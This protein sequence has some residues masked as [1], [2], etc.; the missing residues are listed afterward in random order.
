MNVVSS[1]LITRCL[2]GLAPNDARPS[3]LALS[4]AKSKNSRKSMASVHREIKQALES[5]DDPSRRWRAHSGDR[6]LSP[7]P[8][9]LNTAPS[10]G[11]VTHGRP[12]C[13]FVLL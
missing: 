3:F 1:T 7:R 5:D 12:P 6:Q 10:M 13:R 4:T 2:E 11:M 8:R 9:Q